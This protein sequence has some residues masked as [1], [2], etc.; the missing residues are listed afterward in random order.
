MKRNLGKR[1][2]EDDL[3][4][5]IV[6]RADILR[7]YYHIYINDYSAED[8]SSLR[9]FSDVY[10]DFSDVANVHLTDACLRP[11]TGR[12]LYDLILIYSAYCNVN[13]DKLMNF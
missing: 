13:A 10:D 5:G 3:D 2:N 8:D 1:K 6:T 4:K 12:D 11:I 7:L 9:S